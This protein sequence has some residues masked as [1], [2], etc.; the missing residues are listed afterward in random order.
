MRHAISK[1][2]RDFAAIIGLTRIADKPPE[3]AVVVLGTV[4]YLFI[5]AMA[6]TSF[7][8]TAAWLGAKRWKRLH[9]AGLYY[10]WSVFTLTCLGGAEKDPIAAL[11][12]ALLLAA[13]ALRI[14]RRASLRA[15]TVSVH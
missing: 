7:D 6:A 13:M 4:G 15:R 14:T 10:L 2:M 8:T 5:L 12:V 9:T 11:S 1:H 3:L